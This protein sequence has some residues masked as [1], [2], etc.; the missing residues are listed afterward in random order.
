[1]SQID[2]FFDQELLQLRLDSRV[3]VREAA[4]EL[5]AD[6]KRQIRRNFRNPSIAF[7]RSLKVH[8]YEDASYIRLSPILSV[9]AEPTKIQGNPNL[10]ILLPDGER[11]GFKRIGK[12]FNWTE[13]KRRYGNKLSFAPVAGGSVVLFRSSD[14]VRPIYKIEPVV[15]TRKRI[16]FIERAEEIAKK[17]D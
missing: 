4:R 13:L 16:E 10:W 11:L 12:G 17:Y 6:V 9:H 3:V 8:D 15:E 1:M 14:G 5:E 7:Q 2:K